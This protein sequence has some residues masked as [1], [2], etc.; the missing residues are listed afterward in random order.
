MI[1]WR[2]WLCLES[3]F[4]SLFCKLSCDFSQLIRTLLPFWLFSDVFA[5]CL[6]R[7][8]TKD[9]NAWKKF[10]FIFI[11]RKWRF[12]T[13][14]KHLRVVFR[15]TA[16]TRFNG[17]ALKTVSFLHP[18]LSNNI[19]LSPSLL[20]RRA[21]HW[22]NSFYSSTSAESKCLEKCVLFSDTCTI[23]KSVSHFFSLLF[24]HVNCLFWAVCATA[25]IDVW[26][27]VLVRGILAIRV[28]KGKR[29]SKLK[30]TISGF[31][32]NN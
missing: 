29:N 27:F 11:H 12:S 24:L 19:L 18:C 14:L 23:H 30:K 8:K 17:E 9:S 26:V 32:R 13:P 2:I 6:R 21:Y 16:C 20:P 25:A 15:W 5:S 22:A 3:I 28:E 7:K 1:Y 10:S 4:F 31:E